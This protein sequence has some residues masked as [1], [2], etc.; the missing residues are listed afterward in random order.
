MSYWESAGG[1]TAREKGG[2]PTALKN[3]ENGSIGQFTDRGDVLSAQIQR[4]RRPLPR[5]SRN[6]EKYLDAL[7]T[8]A[9]NLGGIPEFTFDVDV[10]EPDLPSF[11]PEPLDAPLK[12]AQAVRAFTVPSREPE[13]S[14][15]RG[16]IVP[17]NPDLRAKTVQPLRLVPK[18]T[19]D[20]GLK[21][22]QVPTLLKSKPR[23]IALSSRPTVDQR[24]VRVLAPKPSQLIARPLRSSHKLKR[25]LSTPSPSA[26]MLIPRAVKSSGPGQPLIDICFSKEGPAGLPDGSVNDTD[27][28]W[29][30]HWKWF[31][32]DRLKP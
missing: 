7:G 16:P 26:K 14:S 20:A 19:T 18:P 21:P 8:S 6:V 25:A 10:E 17:Q 27:V 24:P 31:E 32:E 30:A 3:S 2:P 15:K 9:D 11:S 28:L 29:K 13:K 5:P 23:K 1:L 12:P 22:T 4:I